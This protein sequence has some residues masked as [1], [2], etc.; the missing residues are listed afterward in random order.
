MDLRIRCMHCDALIQ[1]VFWRIYD[2]EQRVFIRVRCHGDEETMEAD[3]A[4]LFGAR[5]LE[6]VA[7]C[8]PTALLPASSAPPPSGASSLEPHHEDG[9]AF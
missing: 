7:F 8:P 9:Q 3:L 6:G 2:H 4:A 1:D 5:H